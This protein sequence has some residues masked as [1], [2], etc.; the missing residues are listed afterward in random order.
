MD[1]QVPGRNSASKSARGL[2]RL[3]KLLAALHQQSMK[4][5]GG[6]LLRQALGGGPVANQTV[7]PLPCETR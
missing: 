7:S 6:D 3:D 2:A 4:G 5:K 1:V